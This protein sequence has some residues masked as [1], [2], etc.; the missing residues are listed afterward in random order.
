MAVMIGIREKIFE[1][2]D[3]EYRKFQ[4]TLCPGCSNI[5]GVRVPLLRNLAKEIARGDW[6]GYLENAENDYFEEV[7][8]QGMVIGYA[9]AETEELIG[10]MKSFVP[11]ID[12]W[13]VCDSFCTGLK[14]TKKNRHRVWENLH[15]H[16]SSKEEFEIRFGTVMLLNYYVED[17]YIDRVLLLLDGIKHEGYYVKMAVAWAVSV[18]YVKFPG[19][20]MDYLKQ[21]ALD[22]FTFNK[23]LQ[24]ITESLRVDKETKTLIR[25]MRR[26]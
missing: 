12:N 14:F 15:L 9:L 17:D 26:K 23:S 21:N 7:M 24:K 11:K 10:Y 16:L 5:I 4:S 13:A 3:E 18:C 20:T 22:D 8:L 1:L 25:G 6:R 2:A 19:K